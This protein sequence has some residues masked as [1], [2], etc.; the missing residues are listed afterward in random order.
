MPT[1]TLSRR[2]LGVYVPK[3]VTVTDEPR[4]RGNLYLNSHSIWITRYVRAYFG[5][6]AHPA[7]AW[8]PRTGKYDITASRR[9]LVSKFIA[10]ESTP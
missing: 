7:G 8:I 5:V 4:P 3:T 2:L 10:K 1:I 9:K 6:G